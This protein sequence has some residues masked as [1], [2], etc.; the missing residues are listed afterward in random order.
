[1]PF[2]RVLVPS[3]GIFAECDD[4]GV[5]ITLAR[6]VHLAVLVVD[7]GQRPVPDA[8]VQVFPEGG[9]ADFAKGGPRPIFLGRGRSDDRGAVLLEGVP[10]TCDV[11]IEHPRSNTPTHRRILEA[12]AAGARTLRVILEDLDLAAGT[13]ILTVRV[14]DGRTGAAFGGPVLIEATSEKGARRRLAQGPEIRL[15]GLSL[16]KW[17][18]SVAAEGLGA[19]SARVE[20]L[21]DRRLDVRL[22]QGVSISGLVTCAAGWLVRP[23][24]VYA[25]ELASKRLTVTRTD[26]KGRFAFAGM[27]PGEYLL[28][29]EPFESAVFARLPVRTPQGHASPAPVKVRV[30]AG[31]A[32]APVTLPVV[33]VAPL[34]V[35]VA[36]DAA[37]RAARS[38][39]SWA[40]GLHFTV[41][42][43]QGRSV[44]AGG[45]SGVM[46]AAAELLLRLPEGRYTVTVRRRGE[47]LGERTLTAGESWRL[48]TR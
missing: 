41:T 14:I 48:D 18:V 21:D 19:R 15:D 42:D 8:S 16:G 3:R 27:E 24:Q 34:S 29:V 20:L 11:L 31:A 5:T 45:P 46:T 40:Q 36:P 35:M 38:V 47:V 6:A 28:S 30:G 10:N 26:A 12:V 13:A 44:Y 37:T 9:L 4:A 39:W 17:E 33:P 32:P 22:G 23:V 7:R 1:M 2:R 25:R 43:D